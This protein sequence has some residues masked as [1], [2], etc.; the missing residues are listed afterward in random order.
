MYKT[1]KAWANKIVTDQTAP[2]EWS[3]TGFGLSVIPSVYTSYFVS[4]QYL[5]QIDRILPNFVYA[6]ILTR[7][8]VGLLHI[9]FLTFVIEL[10]P[11]TDVRISFYICSTL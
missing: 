2:K 10:W 4:A 7:S 8:R 1:E 3:Y 5:E 9:I 11:L 6:L